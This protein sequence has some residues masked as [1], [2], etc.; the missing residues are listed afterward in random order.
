MKR[1]LRI[2]M[3]SQ[4]LRFLLEDC[5]SRVLESLTS[6]P[7]P[8]IRPT[9]SFSSRMCWRNLPPTPGG[10]FLRRGCAGAP[11]RHPPGDLCVPPFAPNPW[12][13]RC[14]N[15]LRCVPY[16]L[17]QVV[18]TRCNTGCEALF[19]AAARML[20]SHSAAFHE[21]RAPRATIL[22][23]LLLIVISRRDTRCHVASPPF[24]PSH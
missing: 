20:C 24:L 19:R 4:S 12:A 23:L 21:R 10:V 16:A 5:R 6:G 11:S 13:I 7:L 22:G 18:P 3:S 1:E 17:R 2:S 9:G 8:F 15:E 14:A